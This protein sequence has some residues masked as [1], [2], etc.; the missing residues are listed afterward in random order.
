M[1]LAQAGIFA[2]TSK[3]K[4]RCLGC[5]LTC[6]EKEIRIRAAWNAWHLMEQFWKQQCRVR[7]FQGYCALAG[8]S[9][10][11]T[12]SE[13][14]QLEACQNKLARR[15]LALTR[16]IWDTE[17]KQRQISI[18]ELHRKLGIVAIAMGLRIRRRADSKRRPSPPTSAGSK[19]RANA[20]GQDPKNDGCWEDLPI[21]H[22]VG[23][24]AS[25][26]FHFVRDLNGDLTKVFRLC[27]DEFSAIDLTVIRAK[28]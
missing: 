21:C 20:L 23:K 27:A 14:H 15:L 13:L 12:D 26:R 2:G 10:S 16:R 11:L 7:S 8:R 19:F 3:T 6:A 25:K 18:K 17:P 4:V 9:G 22:V 1:G 28:Y 5:R 24:A